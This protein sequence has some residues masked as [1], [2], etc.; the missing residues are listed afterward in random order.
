MLKKCFFIN[1]TKIGYFVSVILLLISGATIHYHIIKPIYHKN[2]TL[3]ANE[4]MVVLLT[5]TIDTKKTITVRRNKISDRI[6]D[7]RKSL[8][9]WAQLPYRM[10]IVENSGYGNP[11]E[12][13]LKNAP[14]IQYISTN[15]PSDP[16]RGIGYGEAKTLKYAIDHLIK[17]NSIYI[18]KITGRYAPTH[19]LSNVISILKRK[20]PTALLKEDPNHFFLKKRSEWFVA[21]RDFYQKLS[22]NCIQT[23]DDKK[24][25]NGFF[26][27]HLHEL[28]DH[29]ENVIKTHNII[30]NVIETR[31]GSS[32]TLLT[33]I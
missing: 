29:S 15:I 24:G 28:G 7:Y 5:M 1:K 32:N 14:H 18:M 6:E 13:I 17:N 21:K 8:T 2:L 30:I 25:E 31:G 12:D 11:F 20:K 33:K 26:E 9:R 22:Q 10:I 4:H 16:N 23:C 3:W 27:A 19:D